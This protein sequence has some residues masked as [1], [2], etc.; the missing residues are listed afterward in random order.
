MIAARRRALRRIAAL[1][2]LPAAAGVRAQAR[3]AAAP[4]AE[5]A[6]TLGEVRLQGWM[7]M[8]WLGL[9][10]YDARLWTPAAQEAL[11]PADY[12]SRAFALELVYA[13]R[14]SGEGIAGRSLDEMRRLDRIDD[15]RAAAWEAAMRAAFP[16]VQAGE[17]LTGLHR[18]GAGA[19]FFHEG[20]P[21]RDIADA[22]F[23]R[24]F[25][26]I[27][28]S[29]RTPEPGLQRELLGGAAS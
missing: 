24:L 5:V 19:R 2:I 4:P 10:I 27:W 20:R 29:P 13:R 26:G 12:P 8:R 14:L 28:L 22:D 23:A 18:P 17:R 21:T 16:D 7:R 15:G 9:A 1:A 6:A 3:P 11:T 25:F